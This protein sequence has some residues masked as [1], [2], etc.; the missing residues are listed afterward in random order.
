MNVAPTIPPLKILASIKTWS[1]L[2][3]RFYFEM[4]ARA[5]LLAAAFALAGCGA[6]APAISRSTAAFAAPEPAAAHV[7]L[8]DYH[9][10]PADIL[11]VTVFQE[12]DLSS[13]LRVSK[14]GTISF[15]LIGVVPVGGLTPLEASRAIRDRLAKGFL[16]DPQ[17]SLTVTQFAKRRFTVLGEV[18]KPGSYDMPDQQDVTVLQAIGMAGGYTRIANSSKVTLMRRSGGKEDVMALNAKRMASGNA[19]SSVLVLPGDVITV[20]ESRF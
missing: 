4:P 15:P 14:E 1:A 5:L 19:E 16:I 12:I 9:I 8:N 6:S 11:D 18:Q 7:D 10:L 3:H 13:R 20:A 17:V 2:R